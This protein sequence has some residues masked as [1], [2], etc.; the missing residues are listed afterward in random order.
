MNELEAR[1]N[2]RNL[3]LE[4]NPLVIDKIVEMGSDINYGAR[5]M[6]RFI[7]ETIETKIAYFIIQQNP[8]DGTIITVDVKDNEF[9]VKEKEVLLN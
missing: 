7:Q 4:Y 3:E 5:P 2:N 1:M 6:K 9:Y 8:S